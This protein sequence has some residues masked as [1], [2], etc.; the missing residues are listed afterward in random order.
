LTI[1]QNLFVYLFELFV[2]LF[3][4]FV[5]LFELFV[6]LFDSVKLYNIKFLTLSLDETAR[7]R[8]ERRMGRRQP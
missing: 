1:A 3:E 6:Y 5:Y 7:A 4:L 8:R 2:Y